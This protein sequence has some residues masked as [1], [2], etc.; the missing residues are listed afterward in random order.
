MSV[1]AGGQELGEAWLA[2]AGSAAAGGSAGRVVAWDAWMIRCS[3]LAGA[4]VAAAAGTG[5]TTEAAGC[6]TAAATG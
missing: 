6:W 3:A 5:W 4:M 1:G 2:G